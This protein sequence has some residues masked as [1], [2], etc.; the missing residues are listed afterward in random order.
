MNMNARGM[1]L[2]EVLLALTILVG[3]ASVSLPVIIESSA[4]VTKKE[5]AGEYEQF[6]ETTDAE[7]KLRLKDQDTAIPIDGVF[8]VAFDLEPATFTFVRREHAG[9]GW[10]VASWRD[11]TVSRFV[12]MDH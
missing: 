2:L 8:S 12:P 7:L 9:H 11:W 6:V 10:F 3:L 5:N 1:T 4:I